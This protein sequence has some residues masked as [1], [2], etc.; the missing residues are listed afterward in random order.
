MINGFEEQ[1]VELQS[2]EMDIVKILVNRF[3]QKKGKEHIINNADI[4]TALETHYK[5]LTTEP[6]IRKVVQY[7]RNNNL[8]I[9]F[10]ANSKGY[11]VADSKE[12]IQAWVRT[13]EQR[14]NSIDTTIQKT[15][16][17]WGI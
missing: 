15:K 17:A 7:I 11:Y 1:T 5:I 13:M 4:C 10:I 16:K 3:N 2:D 12:E 14:R 8:L 9:G 6:R